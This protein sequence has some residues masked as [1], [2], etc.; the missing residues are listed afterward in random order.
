MDEKKTP[1]P[2]YMTETYE[3]M[4]KEKTEK[5]NP[6]KEENS[7]RDYFRQMYPQNVKK[8]LRVIVEVLNRIDVKGSFLYDEYPDNIRLERLTETILRLI[9]LENNM[10]RE[11]QK[12]LVRVLLLEEIMW[13]RKRENLQ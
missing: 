3:R 6:L 2:F 5:K 10:N 7:Q 4:M 1:M 12:N 9:P 8:T 13:R 11:S